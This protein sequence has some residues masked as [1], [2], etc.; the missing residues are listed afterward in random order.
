MKKFQLYTSYCLVAL[1]TLAGCEKKTNY[2]NDPYGEKLEP[3]GLKFADKVPSPSQVRPGNTVTYIVEGATKYPGLEF[4]V[5]N[6][7]VNVE[8]VT[9]STI[10]VRLPAVISTG[11]AKIVVDGQTFAGPLTQ[12]LGKVA[13]DPTFNPGTGTNGPIYSIN[14]F[15]N[16]QFFIGGSFTDYNGNKSLGEINSIARISSTGEFVTGM[17][18]GLGAQE[19]AGAGSILGI[20]ELSDG[21]MLVHG[22]FN[23]YDE[24]RNVKNITILNSTGSLYKESVPILNLT[25]DPEKNTLV[26][27][28]FNGGTDRAVS[29]IF[30]KDEKIFVVG[31]FKQFTNNYYMRSTYNNILKDFFDFESILRMNMDG[32]LDS[33]FL[34]NHDVFP[35]RG[36]FGV[37]GSISDAVMSND[38]K[39]ILVGAFTRYNNRVNSNNIIR[40]NPDG[41]HDQSF[42]V[43][44][45]TDN[46]ITKIIPYK[47]NQYFL[48]GPFVRYNGQEANGIVLINADGSV[49]PSFKSRKFA[50]GVPNYLTVLENGKILVSGSFLRYDDIVREGLMLLNPD[51]SLSQDYNNTGK[52]QGL[53]ID[54]YQGINSIGQKTIT[55]VGQINSFNGKL[56][57]GNIIRLTIQ[58]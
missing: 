31:N 25:D 23:S 38:G 18:F 54:S 10:T 50:Q 19:G 8:A 39:L 4:Y 41:T 11:G 53:V 27:P 57:V 32:S 34:V 13:I 37:N 52:L 1:V 15:K 17:D 48:I 6:T 55:L 35:K 21:K 29:K 51:G 30:I 56:D 58:D 12:I 9:D 45:G 24:D 33:T 20:E 2:G 47:D 7:K 14:R 28:A 43:G 36:G 42:A 16:G 49:D 46:Q 44:T 5:N 22:T 3:L 40:L 26:V